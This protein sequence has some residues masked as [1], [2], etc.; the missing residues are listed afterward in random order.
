MKEAKRKLSTKL[1][2]GFLILGILICTA[3]VS[4][5]YINYKNAVEKQYNDTAYRIA[6]SAMS[7]VDGDAIE[8]YL[9]TGQT[10]DD[11]EVMGEH[12]TSLCRHME[13]NYLYIARLE[14]IDLTYV[15]D[16]DNLE[17]G[18]PAFVLGDQGTI[19]P[20]FVEEANKIV[21]SGIR[22]TNYFYSKSQFGY[23]TSAVVPVYNSEQKIVAI[24][25]V[26]VAMKTLQNML[27]RFMVLTFLAS[28]V[29]TA[30]FIWLY[31][32]V[33]RRGVVNPIRL[34][35]NEA[36]SFIQNETEIS[37]RLLTI[38]TGD[39]IE[40]LAGAIHKMEVDIK[41]YVSNI[42]L[43]TAEKERI[44][45]ELNVATQIQSSMLPSIFPDFVD[46]PEF[47]IFATM[48]PAREVGGDFYDFFLLDEK[49]LAFVIADVSGKGI[50]AALFMVI[51]KTLIKNQAQS[52]HEPDQIFTAVNQQLCENN[53]ANMFVTAWLGIFDLVSG[54]LTWVNAGHNPPLLR[55]REGEYEYLQS[56]PGFVLG[57]M[58]GLTYKASDCFL[59]VGDRL[60]LYTDGITEAT[61]AHLEL[62]G[63]DR[64]QKTLN[65]I[66]PRQPAETIPAVLADI[67]G[68]VGEAPQFDDM[69]MIAIEVLRCGE[70]QLTVAATLDKA[71]ELQAFVRRTLDCA[72]CPEKD[73]KMIAIAVD[74]IFSNVCRYS[75]GE[76]VTV[77]CLAT[78]DAVSLTFTDNGMAYNPLQKESPDVSLSAEERTVG[79]LGIFLVQKLMDDVTYAF[80]DGQNRLTITKQYVRETEK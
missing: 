18:Y 33:L 51:T 76:T 29:I 47:K 56:R 38:R 63:E 78:S 14:G 27:L 4:I 7:Y 31:L 24:L 64:L 77:H 54:K 9:E 50:P 71:D 26:E 41:D 13:A 3:S 10:D 22:S 57:G 16:V 53:E 73:R 69:A 35:T 42:R 23:N 74:E 25:G 6:A 46:R 21:S 59:E 1:V 61:D 39:E 58:S 80:V 19:N 48:M 60:F 15:Y 66:G 30:V 67:D 40:Q 79:G 2:I 37:E 45:A 36:A 28:A 43:I 8:R 70:P 75:Q 55:R 72:G 5:A 20:T 68:F 49:R 44:S 65:R 12:L 34:L 62:Y 32:H 52:G 11:Y 17:D